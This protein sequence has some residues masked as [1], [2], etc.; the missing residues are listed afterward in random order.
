VGG[1]GGSAP[2]L[3]TRATSL[4][5]RRSHA[6]TGRPRRSEF[7]QR[8]ALNQLGGRFLTE[9]YVVVARRVAWASAVVETWPDDVND[10]PFDVDA[11]EEGVRLAESVH[12]VLQVGGEPRRPS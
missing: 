4:R 3:R 9:F 1:G 5:P 10:A 8:A 6:A 11:A 7:P 12:A 2:T